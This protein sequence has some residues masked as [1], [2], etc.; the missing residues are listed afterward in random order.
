MRTNDVLY[1]CDIPTR[2]L[3]T[4]FFSA[5]TD[6]VRWIPSSPSLFLFRLLCD[7]LCCFFPVNKCKKNI[8]NVQKRNNKP[9]KSFPQKK[10]TIAT[11][12][13]HFLS[14][15]SCTMYH[16]HS[17]VKP[18]YRGQPLTPKQNSRH[19]LGGFGYKFHQS[20]AFGFF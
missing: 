8:Y 9:Q 16:F 12:H 1:T 15:N 4:C 3:E 2:S 10:Q 18:H 7:I 14:A 13:T 19:P 11:A 20:Q 17:H 6:T 5:S